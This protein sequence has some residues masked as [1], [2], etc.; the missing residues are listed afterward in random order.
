MELKKSHFSE[1]KVGETNQCC[2]FCRGRL[3]NKAYHADPY[4]K[5]SLTICEDCYNEI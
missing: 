4:Y 3:N 2:G 5:D 1:E